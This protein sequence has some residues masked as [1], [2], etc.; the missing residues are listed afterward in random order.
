MI[1]VSEPPPQPRSLKSPGT[2]RSLSIEEALR[3][4]KSGRRADR[5]R[6]R[7][8]QV[9]GLARA[10]RRRLAQVVA[11]GDQDRARL[12]ESVLPMVRQISVRFLVP[13]IEMDDLV[14]IGSEAVVRCAAKYGLS[15]RIAKFSS[16]S[17]WSI[18]RAMQKA[19]TNNSVVTVPD[20]CNLPNGLAKYRPATREAARLARFGQCSL[21][22]S[23]ERMADQPREHDE[24]FADEEEFRDRRKL[25]AAIR[26]LPNRLRSIMARRLKNHTLRKIG[27]DLG[28]SY[29]WVRRYETEALRRLRQMLVPELPDAEDCRET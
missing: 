16:Y 11:R 12:I 26:R 18:R 9:V 23:L 25:R 15:D 29:E 28:I 21:G 13:G 22:V 24:W 5:A 10:E 7:L 27:R 3:L 2:S 19:V 14:Q 20:W 4:A 1:C 6:K 17:H 8:S